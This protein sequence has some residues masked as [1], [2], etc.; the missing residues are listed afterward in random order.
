ML[1]ADHLSIE[2]ELYLREMGDVF[3]T[4]RQQDS[5]CHASGVALGDG[6]WFVKYSVEAG[7]VPALERA[8]AFHRDVVHQAVTSGLDAELVDRTARHPSAGGGVRR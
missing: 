8:A 7:A 4:F 1:D 5:G 3:A 6:R 2:L